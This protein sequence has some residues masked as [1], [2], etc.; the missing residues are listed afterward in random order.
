MG[1]PYGTLQRGKCTRSNLPE[2]FSIRALPLR[3][4]F[5]R[6]SRAHRDYS[7]AGG[8][9]QSAGNKPRDQGSGFLD[10]LA[11]YYRESR[12]GAL[13]LDAGYVVMFRLEAVVVGDVC[14]II[15]NM[16]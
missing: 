10:D 8:C 5:G 3:R 7:T 13:A 2:S 6:L 11:L 9:S 15:S 4:S 1:V 14:G 16:G 12:E